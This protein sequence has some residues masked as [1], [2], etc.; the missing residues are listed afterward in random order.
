M[1]S[2]YGLGHDHNTPDADETRSVSNK[3][4][5]ALGGIVVSILQMYC[6]DRRMGRRNR[7]PHYAPDGPR[8]WGDLR[9]RRRQSIAGGSIEPRLVNS[10]HRPPSKKWI[11]S[12]R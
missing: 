9:T 11:H 7:T 6:L 3:E 4:R 2:A 12:V 5:S 1:R 10:A 8:Q